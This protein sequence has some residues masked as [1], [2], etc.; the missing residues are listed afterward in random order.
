[1]TGF[2]LS[3]YDY[4]RRHRR[5]AG[6]VV[7]GL[8][9]AII[10]A[11]SQ[12]RL[13]EDIAGFMPGEKDNERIEY[14]YRNLSATEKI[15]VRMTMRGDVPDELQLMDAADGFVHALDSLGAADYISSVMYRVEPEDF[16]LIADF[17]ATNI[18][19]YLDREDYERMDSLMAGRGVERLVEAD[20]ALIVS[21][22]GVGMRET[23]LR[24]PLRLSTG[25][26]QEMGKL[27]VGSR[28]QLKEG[29]LFSER[30]DNLM[31]FIQSANGMSETGRN[32]VL[33][34][35]IERAVSLVPRD[36]QVDYFGGCLV[37]VTN[38]RQ[39]KADSLLSVVI[40]IT[41]ISALLLW[42]FRSLKI[43]AMTVV[44]V[45][46]G[47]GLAVA[48]MV[49]LKG[50]ISAIALGAG[51]VIFGIAVNY[52]MHYLIHLK[53]Q[54]DPRTVLRDITSPM[55]IGNIT[56]VGAFLSL[57]FIKAEAMRDF[58]LFAAFSL[59]GT[60]L[61]VLV[62]LPQMTRRSGAKAAEEALPD[63]GRR[64]RGGLAIWII[65]LLTVVLSF[66]SGRVVFEPDLNKINYMTEAQRRSFA[67]L[68]E[69]TSLGENTMLLVAEGASLDEALKVYER[70]RPLLDSLIGCGAVISSSGIGSLLPSDSTLARRVDL[71]NDFLKTH[72]RQLAERIKQ[73]ALQCGFREEA[74]DGFTDLLAAPIPA[75][76]AERFALL[77]D[78]MLRDFIIDK[79]GRAM[80]TTVV[81]ARAGSGEIV[82]EAFEAAGSGFVFD[83]AR[84][85]G[86]MIDALSGDFNYVLYVCAILVFV[87]LTA[88]FGRLELSLVALLPMVIAWIWILGI[89]AL[90][91][92][93]FNIVNIILA[94]FIFGMGDD[95][96]IF[97]MDGD[98]SRWGS[99]K[100][101][102]ASYRKAIFISFV[103]MM[104]GI[105]SL[106]IAR[107]PAMRSLAQVTIIGMSCVLVTAYTIPGALFG[108]LTHSGGRARKVP[109]TLKYF[110]LSLY[111]LIVFLAG[112]AWLAL[113]GFF[114]LR[115]RKATPERKLGFHRRLC[116]TC[117]WVVRN[118]FWVES[119]QEGAEETFA[120]PGVIICNHASHIDLMYLLQLS[121]K[122]VVVTNQWVWKNPFYGAII[123]YADFLPVADGIG[124][125]L[126]QLRPLVEQ[127]YS[128]AVFPEGTRSEDGSIGRFHRGAFYLA[129]QLGLDIIPVLFHGIGDVLPK[130]E[131]IFRRGR[132]TTHILPRIAPGDGRFGE[133][134]SAR[135]K[136][137]RREYIRQHAAIARRQT[138]PDYYLWAVCHNY[139]YKGSEAARYVRAEKR[140]ADSYAAAIASLPQGA[141]VL[142]RN[143]GMGF[144]A[145]LC[146]LSRG[147]VR[148]TAVEPD[149]EA[150][151]L[152]QNCAIAPANVS[153]AA[154]QPEGAEYDITIDLKEI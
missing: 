117:R 39:I 35:I 114:D 64:R 110:C 87:F 96:V 63:K 14:L 61:F 152:A 141:S 16:G 31:I 11:A 86:N 92:I 129:E 139:I 72:G 4:L 126:E 147:D 130:R 140:R 12:I 143:S 7:A 82:H 53:E 41:L 50:S 89:M 103:T 43:F 94:T 81:Y 38:A 136:S 57:L 135:A 46:F 100:Q 88:A 91:G 23:L 2:F 118:M 36:V 62:I 95:Y 111:A 112:S 73:S 13:E 71:W 137:V 128:I 47:A 106:V 1:M 24:D 20:R 149:G 17:V 30:G 67:N 70:Q 84:M 54:G 138:G 151:A 40:A 154:R 8:L 125:S 83:P 104:I 101:V 134:Y 32:E 85:R 3:I 76:G 97:I 49:L 79:P 19:L 78:K 51:S 55:L 52:S 121:P 116:A 115:L 75:A 25:T 119:V 56:T 74:F 33:A 59:I 6:W 153:F 142:V 150:T 60:I 28:Y 44:P 21:P 22:M 5:L 66:W 58:G 27:G 15:I 122:I 26:L 42:Y 124:S 120:A 9:A 109:V 127:G 145:I 65:A 37:A 69:F 68:S 123:R 10:A 80:V 102:L 148:V 93:D 90:L 48:A 108:L 113:A 146:A 18:P 45:I 99:G 98:I 133:G 34:D 131:L 144:F 132:V 77:K 105:G 107:H 29:Y